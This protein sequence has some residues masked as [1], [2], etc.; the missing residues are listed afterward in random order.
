M[1]RVPGFD[2]GPSDPF[3]DLDDPAA[4]DPATIREIAGLHH[5]SAARWTANAHTFAAAE[6]WFDGDQA[7]AVDAVEA[8]ATHLAPPLQT[9]SDTHTSAAAALEVFAAA[10]DDIA[11]RAGR[12]RA[13]VDAALAD[14]ARTREVLGDLGGGRL[15]YLTDLHPSSETNDWPAGPPPLPAY[16]IDQAVMDGTLTAADVAA[17]HA[18]V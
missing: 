8:Q 6:L 7:E 5:A 9:L 17:L 4:G 1:T 18:G 2:A 11:G 3:G 12:L 13:D 15:P 16:L 14:I 10:I